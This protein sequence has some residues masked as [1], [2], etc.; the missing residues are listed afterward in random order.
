MLG[1]TAELHN[2]IRQWV[3]KLE[4]GAA[5]TVRRPEY[6]QNDINIHIEKNSLQHW[7][8]T[9]AEPDGDALTAGL[10]RHLDRVQHLLR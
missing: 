5:P 10:L 6:V 4:R 8:D 7:I 3:K 1:F 9:V 2:E